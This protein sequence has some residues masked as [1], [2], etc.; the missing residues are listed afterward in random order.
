MPRRNRKGRRP[1]SRPRK[2]HRERESRRDR[3]EL[4]GLD[5]LP[6]LGDGLDRLDR[7]D[8]LDDLPLIAEPPP[9]PSECGSCLEWSPPRD[10]LALDRGECH[11][12]ASGVLGPSSDYPACNWFRPRR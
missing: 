5:P 10:E 9:L 12:P 7:L 2:Y 11:H 1:G 8:D 6:M 4:V 3:R